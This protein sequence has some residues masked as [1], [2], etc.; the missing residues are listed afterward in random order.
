MSKRMN[1]LTLRQLDKKL[2]RIDSGQFLPEQGWIRT[3]RNALGMTLAQLADRI[4]VSRPTVSEYEQRERAGTITLKTLK[5]AADGLECNLVYTFVPREESLQDLRKQAA[6]E[7]ARHIV[8]K[9]SQSMTLE[10]QEVS[11]EEREEQIREFAR[12]LLDNWDNMIW[13]VKTD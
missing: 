3:I 4:G 11:E 9:T 2:D 6:R 5:K 8:E 13:E 7:T 1:E 10:D 12:E